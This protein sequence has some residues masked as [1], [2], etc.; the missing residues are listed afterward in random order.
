MKVLLAVCL[1]GLLPSVLMAD[2]IRCGSRIITRGSTSAELA[3]FCGDPAQVT[4]SSSYIG[5]RAR[6]TDGVDYG[7][8]GELVV[9]I[10]TYNFGP[11]QLM[12][13]VRIENGMV[14]QIDSLGYGYNEP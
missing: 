8:A 3:T 9:E 1:L 10:W 6:G 5:G 4:K 7:T 2:S 13:R 12:E 11:N 14:A